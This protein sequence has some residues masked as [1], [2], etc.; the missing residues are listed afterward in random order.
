MKKIAVINYCNANNYGA[1]LL[2]LALCNKLEKYAFDVRV[3]D[4]QP[5]YLMSLYKMR[6]QI[7]LPRKMV[8]RGKKEGKVQNFSQLVDTIFRSLRGD[9]FALFVPVKQKRFNKFRDQY[10]NFTE[11]TYYTANDLKNSP[12]IADYYIVGG[13]QIWNKDNTDD[14]FDDSY[15]LLFGNENIRRLS[16]SASVGLKP[17]KNYCKEII[18]RTQDFYAC[19]VR[20]KSLSECLNKYTEH[21]KYEHVCDPVFF[22]NA[23]EWSQF[24]NFLN[25]KNPY[26]IT[27]IF[28]ENK[29]LNKYLDKLCNK[30]NCK[31]IDISH[32]SLRYKKVWKRVPGC[33]PAE[34]LY[35]IKNA[36]YVV[37][38]SFH[39][40]AFSTIFHKNFTAFIREGTG[41]RLV[42]F[43]KNLGLENRV[44]KN[45]QDISCFLLD[46]DYKTADIKIQ[47]MKN[48]GE[49][50][51]KKYV[52]E[53]EQLN[54][55]SK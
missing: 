37:T 7:S 50:F 40:L 31:I 14:L 16:Y 42:D 51:L 26:I 9:Y 21:M 19:S 36:T 2:C 1:V 44:F 48:N 13:D 4:Y 12:P 39:C 41:S 43:L 29:E 55:N 30:L 24:A 11:K 52:L 27:Y 5:N 35:Y 22:L 8:Q 3:I 32:Y 45:Q 53:S 54:D 38:D 18:N 34:F 17:D 28:S 25:I 46:V 10:L 49:Q 6:A 47:E 33:G 15:F 20:E 23:E